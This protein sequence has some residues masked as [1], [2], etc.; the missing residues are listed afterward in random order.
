MKIIFL[1][2]DGVLNHWPDFT[3]KARSKVP[4]KRGHLVTCET[5][6]IN[7]ERVERVDRIVRATEARVVVSS[8]WRIYHT[9]ND[10][11][12]LLGLAG[13]TSR[14]LSR[15]PDLRGVERRGGEINLWL[16][17]WAGQ[18]PQDPIDS[19]VILDDDSDMEPHLDRLVQ[20]SMATGLLDEHAD[21]AI[22]LLTQKGVS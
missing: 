14:V 18:H 20:T 2:F 17:T 15:T 12:R 3:V 4:Q 21:R 8:T 16:A 13:L 11:D 5:G 19:F 9:V 22:D 10:L 6:P 7:C 1:D